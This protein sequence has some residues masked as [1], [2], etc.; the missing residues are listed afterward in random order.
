MTRAELEKLRDL[1]AKTR[2]VLAA[3]QRGETDAQRVLE[4]IASLDEALVATDPK[5]PR[6]PTAI[7][8]RILEA[9]SD[10]GIDLHRLDLGLRSLVPLFPS[11]ALTRLLYHDVRKSSLEQLDRIADLIG[12]ERAWLRTGEGDKRTKPIPPGVITAR[13]LGASESAIQAVLERDA[14]VTR[15]EQAWCMAFLEETKLGSAEE[16]E[17]APSSIRLR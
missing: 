9:A 6:R 2:E 11:G 7:G 1:L 8:A 5:T 17:P 10:V 16:P 15:D 13:G 3:V 4:T 14:N 12:C